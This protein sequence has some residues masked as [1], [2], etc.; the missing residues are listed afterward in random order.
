VQL[1]PG[2][3]CL[4]PHGVSSVAPRLELRGV[5][6]SRGAEGIDGRRRPILTG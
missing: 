5:S 2:S 1:H 4:D 6:R 3:E